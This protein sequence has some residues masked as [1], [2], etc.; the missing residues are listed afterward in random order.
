MIFQFDRPE[1]TT[2]EIPH[3]VVRRESEREVARVGPLE[4]RLWSQGKIWNAGVYREDIRLSLT[5][6]EWGYSVALDGGA[7]RAGVLAEV[8]PFLETCSTCGC[9]AYPFRPRFWW[10]CTW[11]ASLPAE[12]RSSCWSCKGKKWVY[13]PDPA[14]MEHRC[15][16]T[17]CVMHKKV[18]CKKCGSAKTRIMPKKGERELVERWICERCWG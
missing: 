13:A 5:K 16:N 6:T 4:I 14:K 1:E 3:V 2:Y 12:R 11:C 9:F 18:A 8:E 7:K 10:P 15:M 17:K